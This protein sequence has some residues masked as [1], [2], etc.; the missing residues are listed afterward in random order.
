MDLYLRRRI[1]DDQERGKQSLAARVR[2]SCQGGA[3]RTR[4]ILGGLGEAGRILLRGSKIAFSMINERPE[5][6]FLF[7]LVSPSILTLGLN[8]T[9]WTQPLWENCLA[10]AAVA[11]ASV[12]KYWTST[13]GKAAE[14]TELTELLKLA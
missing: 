3:W 12:H 5:S 11:A 7:F 9:N 10:P 6:L 13:F 2:R 4:R 14:N 1:L 8:K